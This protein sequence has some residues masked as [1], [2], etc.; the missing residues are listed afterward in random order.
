MDGAAGQRTD[1]YHGLYGTD[2]VQL[3]PLQDILLQFMYYMHQTSVE[4]IFISHGFQPEWTVKRGPSFRI[5]RLWALPSELCI[6]FK[7]LYHKCL[8]DWS[9]HNKSSTYLMP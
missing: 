6:F 3:Q 7:W 1:I 8:I 4:F 5:A 2:R 9:M